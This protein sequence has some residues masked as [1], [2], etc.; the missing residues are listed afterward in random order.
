MGK[1]LEILLVKPFQVTNEV[2]PP[3]GLGYLAS[4]VR[5]KHNVKILD[6]IKDRILEDAFENFL[7]DKNY[8]VIGFQCYTADF[9]TVKR[10][11]EIAHKLNPH[12]VLL[13]GGPQPTLSPDKTIEYLDKVNFIFIGEAEI[14]FPMLIE[15]ISKG[16]LK[17]EALKKIPGIAY[18]SK[19]KIIKN[20]CATPEELDKY[21]PCWD[22]LDLNSY[23]IAPHGAFCK[24]F[25][26]A[27]M[28]TTRGCPYQCT[29]CVGPLISGRK[30][31]R[32][33]VDYI[34]KQITL[35]NK[36]YGIKEIHIEDDNFTV[37][38]KF[39]EEFCNALIEKNLGVTWVCPNGIRLDTL[40]EELVNLMKK[41][42]LY[43]ISVGIE[44][45]SDRIRELMKKN[46][47]TQ[48]IVE[49]L[50]MIK[51]TGIG[52][53]GF[54]ILGFPGETKKEI[55]ETIKFA[56]SLPLK[57]A[58]FSAF[59]PFPGTEIFNELT[60]TGEI[61]QMAWAD[62]TLDKVIWSPAGISKEE[63]IKLRKKA[64]LSF[65]LRPKIL[66]QMLNEIKNFEN[67]KFIIK[68][69]YRWLK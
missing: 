14:G 65:Y 4:T 51:K 47:S 29:Y 36:T 63:L 17:K 11:T 39:V 61:K 53:T 9:D 67:L 42:G 18:L 21:N 35:L 58:T 1:K 34:I 31:R 30:I 48:K 25:P 12:A 8:D 7:K 40:D 33:S 69:I 57:R 54:F 56:C 60:K 16:S 27:P 55:E 15:A 20:K 37:N 64:F 28:I 26:T 62:F 38:R 22:L 32:H 52:V 66:F 41:S 46:L 43:S 24:Q 59:K 68:R 19:N 5:D 13:V 10:L 44:S 50:D 45:G 49:K 2:Q 23:P 6:C 3:L